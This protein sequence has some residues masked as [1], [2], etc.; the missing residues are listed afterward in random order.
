MRAAGRSTRCPTS[1]AK[2]C[3]SARTAAARLAQLA[4]WEVDRVRRA[5]QPAGIPHHRAQ[6]RRRTCLRGLPHASTRLLSDIDVMVPARSDRRRRSR[7][8]SRPAG[9]APSSTRTTRSITAS[10]RTRFRRCSYPGRV[11][12]VDV[13]H[14]ICPPISRLRPDAAGVLGSSSRAL[15]DRRFALLSPVD[16][17][18]HA[19]VH[20]FFDSDFDGRF[21]DLV[22][23]HELLGAF[24]ADAAFWPALVD[25][26]AAA[27]PRPAAVL[28]VRNAPQRAPHAD[29]V[30]TR[31]ARRERSRR[32]R[33]LD[34]WMASTLTI[35]ADAGRPG[36]LAAGR[37]AAAY[38]CST[39][40]RTGC[41]CRRT[42]WCR[43]LSAKRVA[44]KA[45][46]SGRYA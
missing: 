32:R 11:L 43:I 8:C 15:P 42:C 16:S 5:L 38:G 18:L 4:R 25:A 20:L 14:T 10:G 27:G 33:R 31:C 45:V 37:I 3:L 41:G 6:G 9:R 44:Q 35:G 24:G 36:A 29:S 22:D 19:A 46:R 2:R 17:V 21:R 23:L 34:R 12:G 13:H 7:R 28:R 39:C 30:R 26:R 40:A 1:P